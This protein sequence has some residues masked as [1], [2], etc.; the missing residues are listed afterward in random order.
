MCPLTLALFTQYTALKQRIGIE[1]YLVIELD[2]N[3]VI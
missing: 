2:N 1:K 3:N